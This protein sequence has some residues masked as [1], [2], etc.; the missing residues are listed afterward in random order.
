MVLERILKFYTEEFDEKEQGI[1]IL[2]AEAGN[3]YYIK[4][5][6]SVEGMQKGSKQKADL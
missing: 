5:L 6:V 1:D 4:N 3:I 2:N